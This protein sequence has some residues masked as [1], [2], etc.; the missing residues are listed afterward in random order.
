MAPCSQPILVYAGAGTSHDNRITNVTIAANVTTSTFSDSTPVLAASNNLLHLF[1]GRDL[2][3]AKNLLVVDPKDGRLRASLALN[4]AFASVVQVHG[5]AVRIVTRDN[6][7]ERP[8]AD[9]MVTREPGVVLGIFTA[10]CVPVLLS[11]AREHVSAALH[12]GWR[13]VIG[14]IAG[15]G[16]A[17]MTSLG[18]A[19]AGPATRRPRAR[20]PRAGARRRRCARRR[21]RIS[22]AA[23]PRR[24]LV[25]G[26]RS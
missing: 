22:R 14:A 12:A 8:R 15:A 3:R 25:E 4:L 10:D 7:A 19:P 23:R 26:A 21:S 24:W 2:V 18:T 16:V 20:A 17:A 6:A 5:N 13:G 11:D 1:I 9:A